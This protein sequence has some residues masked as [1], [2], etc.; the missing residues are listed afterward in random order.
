[1]Y[2]YIYMT[3]VG[4]CFVIEGG[5]KMI[6]FAQSNMT[7][8][9]IVTQAQLAITYLLKPPPLKPPRTQVPTKVY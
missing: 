2:I 4:G 5:F 7:N 1:M 3:C 8:S 6:D 9:I